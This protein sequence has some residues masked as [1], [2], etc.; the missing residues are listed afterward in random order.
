[1]KIDELDTSKTPLQNIKQRF[2]ALRN[3]MLADMLRRAG[4]PYRI[5]FGL[6][7]PQIRQVAE[8]FGTDHELAEVLWANDST[9]ESRLI[10]PMLADRNRFSVEDAR[11]WLSML[12]G[13]VE[14]VDILCWALLR[15]CAYAP[16]LVD[17]LAG[18]D[19]DIR[20]YTA[21]RLAANLV[22]TNPDRYRKIA[23]NER[24]RGC[25]LTANLANQ[26]I[27][28]SEFLQNG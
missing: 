6:N 17:E 24:Q 12:N 20:R 7:L 26:V 8:V 4:S 14:E 22:S 21:L 15:H 27:E 25:E 3:G 11:R 28:E 16:D 5:I 9:R 10:A 19:E 2:F 18:S 23:E 13:T 1:M